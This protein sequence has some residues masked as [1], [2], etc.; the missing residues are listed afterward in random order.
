[1]P[2]GRKAGGDGCPQA[3]RSGRVRQLRGPS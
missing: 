1:M 3:A 2:P